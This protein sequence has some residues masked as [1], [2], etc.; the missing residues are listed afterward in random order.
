[1][2]LKNRVLNVVILFTILLFASH[3]TYGQ[4][5]TNSN[6]NKN[7]NVKHSS[8]SDHSSH[9]NHCSTVSLKKQ[10]KLTDFDSEKRDIKLSIAKNT[11][12]VS[13]NVNCLIEVGELTVEVYNSKGKKQG[14]FSV[15]GAS[16]AKYK[17]GNTEPVEGQINFDTSSP[18][19]G[20]WVI[21]IIPK[22]AIGKI[23]VRSIQNVNN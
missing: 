7:V 8:H 4:T 11:S 15:E 10:I 21:K 2:K 1:M 14:D 3:S 19:E 16:K 17:K 18:V 22:Q 12:R 20:D 23:M 6:T 13:L 9:S 5:N